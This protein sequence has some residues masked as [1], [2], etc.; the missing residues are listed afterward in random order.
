[1]GKDPYLQIVPLMDLI[2]DFFPPLPDVSSL[3]NLAA[4]S[5]LHRPLTFLAA[6][7]HCI[8][9]PHFVDEAAEGRQEEGIFLP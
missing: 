6:G 9:T 4:I 8:W 1:M 2:Q 3:S 5:R 7:P